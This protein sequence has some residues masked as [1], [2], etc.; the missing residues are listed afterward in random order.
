[1]KDEFSLRLFHVKYVCFIDRIKYY[2]NYNAFNK[3]IRSKI[4]Y[5][6]KAINTNN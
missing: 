3:D 1:M 4:D 6:E 2:S 5:N